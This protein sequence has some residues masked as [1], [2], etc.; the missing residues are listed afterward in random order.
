MEVCVKNKERRVSTIL[1]TV[2]LMLVATL[3]FVSCK[4]D[5]EEDASDLVSIKFTDEKESSKSLV[6]SRNFNKD[7]YYWYYTASKVNANTPS[8]GA[9]SEQ[10]K[11]GA[12]NEKGLSA[13]VGPF[14]QG[15][16][17]FTL[18]GY[19]EKKDTT[20][21]VL[22][23]KGTASNAS[24]DKDSG[25]DGVQSIYVSVEPQTTEEGKGT[26]VIS[27]SIVLKDKAG[28]PYAANAYTV[29]NNNDGSNTQEGTITENTDVK[30]ENLKSG[31]YKVVVM[32]KG[33]RARHFQ[34]FWV[35]L[36]QPI[37]AQ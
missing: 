23:Y 5:M 24:I 18:Y 28:N 9:T 1:L 22:A 35:H 30:I 32:C 37:L 33:V 36:N 19:T 34:P 4:V 25:T 11:I 21:A 29:T 20:G 3:A 8:T 7:D 2:L 27:S 6:S 31:A 16:W 13:T 14:S 10:T 15:L 26:L 12:E 17:N